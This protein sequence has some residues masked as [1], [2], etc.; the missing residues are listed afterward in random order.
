MVGLDDRSR[1]LLLRSLGK[2]PFPAE[3]G[4]CIDVGDGRT[5]VSLEG[6]SL[7]ES[8]FQMPLPHGNDVPG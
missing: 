4:G 3:P 7:R 1:W 5:S 8:L 6:G 2:Y